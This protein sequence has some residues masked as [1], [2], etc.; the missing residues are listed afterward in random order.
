MYYPPGW[1]EW[2]NATTMGLNKVE[3]YVG[4]ENLAMTPEAIEK[5][6][7]MYQ[8]IL[9]DMAAPPQSPDQIRREWYKTLKTEELW[10]L[11]DEI[12]GEIRGR[13]Q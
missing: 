11:H 12:L 6:F 7:K 4:D 13:T 1:K 3:P 2:M 5:A 10:N 8:G 9:R